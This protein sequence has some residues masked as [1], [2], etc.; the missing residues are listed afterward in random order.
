VIDT[1]RSISLTKK[2]RSGSPDNLID[3]Q[4]PISDNY[5]YITVYFLDD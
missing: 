5:F 2:C 3:T 4:T 1:L